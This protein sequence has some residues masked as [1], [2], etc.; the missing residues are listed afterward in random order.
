[1]VSSHVR[2]GATLLDIPATE[3]CGERVATLRGNEVD[4]C[5]WVGGGEFWKAKFQGRGFEWATGGATLERMSLVTGMLDCLQGSLSSHNHP[6]PSDTRRSF[7]LSTTRCALVPTPH[8]TSCRI[9]L[10]RAP[11]PRTGRACCLLPAW[12]C[13]HG[14]QE[15]NWRPIEAQVRY[16]ATLTRRNKSSEASVACSA[17]QIGSGAVVSANRNTRPRT[18]ALCVGVRIGLQ[19]T[20]G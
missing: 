9:G 6:R 12:P 11:R 1:M 8:A 10:P 13:N 15:F 2:P 20:W 7:I 19:R 4:V 18:K 3:Q 16:C 14:R 5:E 17:A